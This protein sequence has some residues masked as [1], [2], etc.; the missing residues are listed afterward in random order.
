MLLFHVLM[1]Y[2]SRLHH[3]RPDRNGTTIM[4]SQ[5]VLLDSLSQATKAKYQRIVKQGIDALNKVVSQS[6]AQDKSH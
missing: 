6:V 3:Q 4:E 1:R 2:T 5:L